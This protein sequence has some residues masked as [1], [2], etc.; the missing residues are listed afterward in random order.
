MKDD[1]KVRLD[2]MDLLIAN[3]ACAYIDYLNPDPS[4]NIRTVLR[5]RVSD[6]FLRLAK[7]L[8]PQ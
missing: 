8:L 3:L 2:I 6:G 7:D 1:S 5:D 4:A